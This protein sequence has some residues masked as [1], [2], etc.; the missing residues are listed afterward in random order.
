ME[1]PSRGMPRADRPFGCG[2]GGGCGSPLY[3]R[4]RCLFLLLQPDAGL[5]S[6]LTPP[7]AGRERQQQLVRRQAGRRSGSQRA[8]SSGGGR[9]LPAGMAQPRRDASA[10]SLEVFVLNQLSTLAQ[11]TSGRGQANKDVREAALKLLGGC[12]CCWGAA[13]GQRCLCCVR[14]RAAARGSQHRR[15]PLKNGGQQPLFL[16]GPTLLS[17]LQRSWEWLSLESPEAG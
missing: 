9:G 16:S 12:C 10:V 7:T 17:L 13:A 4:R 3:P 14:S 6:T 11:E 2:G 1:T 5:H 15:G 8:R